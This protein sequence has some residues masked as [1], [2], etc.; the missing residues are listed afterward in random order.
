MDAAAKILL[1]SRWAP[2][3]RREPG[4][5]MIDGAGGSEAAEI[6]CLLASHQLYASVLRPVRASLEDVFL[7]LTGEGGLDG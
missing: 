5:L 3:L 2:Q 1:A 6:N 7:E 4:A